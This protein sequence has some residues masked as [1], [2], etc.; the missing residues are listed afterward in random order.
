MKNTIIAGLILLSGNLL[1]QNPKFSYSLEATMEV[2][3]D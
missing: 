1:A 2:Y 3:R